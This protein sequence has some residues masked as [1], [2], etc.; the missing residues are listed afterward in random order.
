M[1]EKNKG[2]SDTWSSNCFTDFFK[3][4]NFSYICF[5]NDESLCE[6]GICFAWDGEGNITNGIPR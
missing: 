1:D 4:G 2:Q 6:G 3:S 5:G